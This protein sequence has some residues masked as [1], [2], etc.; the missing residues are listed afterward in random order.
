MQV[1]LNLLGNAIK[2]SDVGDEIAVYLTAGPDSVLIR[3]AD[4]GIGMNEGVLEHIFEKFYQ[5][6]KSRAGEGNGLGL[7]LVKRI[8]E[9]CGG[10]IAAESKPEEGSVFTVTLPVA[11]A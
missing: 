2:F 6:D 4:T 3:V 8:V 10:S 1:W 11:K 5:G 9:L 7:A